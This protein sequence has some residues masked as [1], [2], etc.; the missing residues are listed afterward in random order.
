MRASAA[1]M[2]VGLLATSSV[3][4]ASGRA[5]TF[6][7]ADGTALAGMVYESS[8]RPAPAVVFVHA[9]G[10]AKQDWALLAD[11]V[12]EAGA[13]VLTFDLRGHGGSGGD[14]TRLPQ[15]TTDVRAAL[16]WLAARPG[17]RRGAVALVGASLGASLAALVASDTPDVRAVALV[18][19]S[20]DYR[21][22]RLDS[23]VL[24]ALAG[25]PLW[26]SASAEDP[27]A[28]RSVRD[29]AA[30]GGPVEQRLSDV[31]AHGSAL[32]AGDPSLGRALVDWLQRTLVF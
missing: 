26:L 7:A 21:G 16:T 19:P 10:G 15:M 22:V 25:R 6:T 12:Q 17:L 4:M 1:A 29:L 30:A 5:V 31:R 3:A 9:L 20:I 2:V 8:N 23:T 11:R 14:A 27:Y 24:K 18:S 28:L 13:T 32:L